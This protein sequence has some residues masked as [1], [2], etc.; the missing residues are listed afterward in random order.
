MMA[1]AQEERSF[2]AVKERLDEIAEE[3]TREGLPLDEALALYEEAV[4]L[5]LA[6]CDLSE[7]DL[8]L[9]AADEAADGEAAAVADAE[10]APDAAAPAVS[11]FDP[12]A[13]ASADDGS[14]LG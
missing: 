11:G 10:S 14:S 4:Q 12:D 7:A 5:G 1:S 9:A 6:A 13:A 3:V 2:D 8:G